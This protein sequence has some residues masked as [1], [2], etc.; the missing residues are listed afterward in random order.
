MKPHGL[1]TGLK[2]YTAG[3]KKATE[4]AIIKAVFEGYD[5]CFTLADYFQR[6]NSS[7]NKIL[8]RLIKQGRLTRKRKT[9]FDAYVYNIEPSEF[10]KML[11][12]KEEHMP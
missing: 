1:Q 12:T 6:D 7:V 4:D 9:M 3:R 5:T 8:K 11:Q 10:I 2:R